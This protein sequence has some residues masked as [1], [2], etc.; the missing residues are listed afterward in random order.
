[1]NQPDDIVLR[2]LALIVEQ[3]GCNR[4]QLT[5]DTDLERDLGLGGDKAAA[6]LEW[7]RREFDIDMTN[8]QFEQHF[9]SQGSPD[10]PWVVAAVVALPTSIA[11]LLMLAVLSWTTGLQPGRIVGG[12]GLFVLAYLVSFALVALTTVVL[13]A[14][15]AQRIRKIPLTVRH[16]ID[17][18]TTRSWPLIQVEGESK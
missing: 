14:M 17:A 13:P 5:L 16:L 15:R 18:A 9:D 4:N 11:V 10:W 6:L 1:M 2:V 8:F 12:P 3:T 7:M